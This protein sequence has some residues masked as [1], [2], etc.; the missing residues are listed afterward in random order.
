[1]SAAHADAAHGHAA[2]AAAP[3]EHG[4]EIPA[5][6]A[7]RSITP[8]PEDYVNLPGASSL[9]FPLAWLAIAALL[10]SY[11]L[12]GGWGVHHMDDHGHAES[13]TSAH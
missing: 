8:A 10:I 7:Q 9:V 13:D 1:M 11:A 2:H 12:G 6:P 5:A 4:A 3:S